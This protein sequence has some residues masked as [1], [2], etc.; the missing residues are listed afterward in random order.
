[1]PDVKCRHPAVVSQN[2]AVWVGPSPWP[3]SLPY[4]TPPP[5]TLLFRLSNVNMAG[6]KGASGSFIGF[7]A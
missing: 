5:H 7:E 1:M 4:A 3:P 6:G 2:I